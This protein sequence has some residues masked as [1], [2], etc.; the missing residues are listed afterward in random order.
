MCKDILRV[1]MSQVKRLTDDVQSLAGSRNVWKS[2][3][4]AALD[5]RWID[6][7]EVE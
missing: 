3:H 5:T 6:V 2:G 1:G 7:I 4:K